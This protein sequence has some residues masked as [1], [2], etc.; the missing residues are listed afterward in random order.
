MV[1]EGVP[2]P[3]FLQR[4]RIHFISKELPFALV[5]KSAQE[6]YGRLKKRRIESKQL[7]LTYLSDLF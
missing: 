2:T 7:V 5:Q 4:V 1:G 3:L 6:N